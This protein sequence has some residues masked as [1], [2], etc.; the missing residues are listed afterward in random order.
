MDEDFSVLPDD[1][2]D[3]CHGCI[4]IGDVRCLLIANRQ[5][6][7]LKPFAGFDF[8]KVT[9]FGTQIENGIDTFCSNVIQGY[10]RKGRTSHCD[11]AGN[12]TDII[13]R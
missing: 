12:P 3:P 7:H 5:I 8:L 6:M 10:I 11:V 4:Q 9:E 13:V 2:V 1:I